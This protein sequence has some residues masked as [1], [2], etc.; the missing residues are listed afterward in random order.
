MLKLKMIVVVIILCV[1]SSLGTMILS[2]EQGAKSISI[3]KLTNA[4]IFHAK[5]KDLNPSAEI[6]QA[7]Q[8]EIS[9][10]ID[11]YWNIHQTLKF[12]TQVSEHDKALLAKAKSLTDESCAWKEAELVISTLTLNYES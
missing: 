4:L 12:Y 6:Q 10:G 11:H 5:I 7:L 8:Q 3:E 2:W 9:C 1:C